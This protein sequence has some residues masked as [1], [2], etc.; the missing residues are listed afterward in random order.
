MLARFLRAVH[1]PTVVLVKFLHGDASLTFVSEARKDKEVCEQREYI[2]S[3]ADV[4]REDVDNKEY[5]PQMWLLSAITY[6]RCK[7][8]CTPRRSQE[9]GIGKI[10]RLVVMR[11][12]DEMV[13]CRVS[14][15]G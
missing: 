8:E 14:G 9:V 4:E 1:L 3:A 6:H 5:A 11:R 10:L 12:D 15:V 7:K 2:L 13:G